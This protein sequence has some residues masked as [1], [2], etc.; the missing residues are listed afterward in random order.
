[1]KEIDFPL[2]LV[3]VTGVSGV[4]YLY[5]IL[6]SKITRKKTILST[7]WYDYA[8][9]LFPIFFIVLAVRSFL[10]EPFQIPSASMQPNLHVGD[11]IIVNKYSYGLRLPVIDYKFI[12]ISK[13]QRGDV[14]VFKFPGDKSINFIKRLV[15]MPGDEVS[16]HNKQLYINNKLI[17]HSVI[18]KQAHIYLEKIFDM[19]YP[20]QVNYDVNDGSGKWIVPP[21]RYFV[22]GDNRDNSH[23][24]RYW[25]TVPDHLLI[26]KAVYVWMQ[27]P[28]ISGLPE[29]SN[30]RSIE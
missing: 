20:I 17:E 9:T 23:D 24:S 8:H 30:N 15:G 4:L 11:F 29:F 7:W 2:L 27:W 25:G 26:G 10:F 18:D 3:I 16:Y 12:D 14:V 22:M 13:P 19:Q 1:M 5:G 6:H 28:D 21:N